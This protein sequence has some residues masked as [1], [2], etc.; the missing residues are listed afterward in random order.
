[1]RHQRSWLSGAQ[2]ISC[3]EMRPLA[4][5]AKTASDLGIAKQPYGAASESVHCPIKLAG[6]SH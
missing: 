2:S 5:Q 1:M 3:Q 6:D 4:I